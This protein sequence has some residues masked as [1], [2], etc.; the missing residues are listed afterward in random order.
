MNWHTLSARDAL[1][2]LETD[3]NHGLNQSL[4]NERYERY[5]PNVFDKPRPVSLG[6]RILHHLRDIS[7]IILLIAALIAFYM[8]ATTGEG[9]AKVGVILLIVV[10]NVVLAITQESK[11]EKAL[12]T[13]A[14]VNAHHCTA[15]RCGALMTIPASELVPGDIIGLAAGDR[16]PADA[17]LTSANNLQV[18]EAMLTGESMP[19][20][21]DPTAA[22]SEEAPLAERL[23]VVYSGSYVSAGRAE[24]VVYATG[25]HTEMGKIAL[26]LNTTTKQVT[27]LQKRLEALAK[28]IA[29]IALGSGILIFLIGVVVYGDPL[30]QMLLTGISLAVAAVPETLPVIVTLIMANGIRAMVEAKTIIRRMPAVETVGSTSIICSDKTGTLTQNKMVIRKLWR[31]DGPV[32][33]ASATFSP[34]EQHMLEMLAACTNAVPA[35]PEEIEDHGNDIIGDP[36][37]AAIVR[38]LLDKGYTRDDLDER[39]PRVFELPF[40]STRKLMTTVHTTPTGYLSITKGA[41]DRIPLTQSHGDA[42]THLLAQQ[43]HDTFA[44]QALRVLAVATREWTVLPEIMDAAHL[45]KDLDL[46]GVVGLIDPPRPESY[47]AVAAAKKAG[48]RTVMITG[49][50]SATAAAIARDIGILEGDAHVVSGVELARMS[51]AE[52]IERVPE[53]AVYARVSPEDKI[54]IV[55]AWQE[56]GEVIT[57]TGDGVNDAPALKAADV[58]AA[59]GIAGTDVSKNAADVIITDDNFATIVAAVREG[60]TAYDNIRKVVHFLLSVNFAEILVM[61]IGVVVGWGAPINSVQLLFINVIADG[62]PGFSLSR[63]PAEANLMNRVPLK[64]NASLFAEGLGR[65][66]GLTSAI[67]IGLTLAAFAIGRFVP[68]QGLA[69]DYVRGTTM[70]FLVLAWSSALNIFNVRAHDSLLAKATGRNAWLNGCVALS[71]LVSALAVLLPFTQAS[72]GL[73]PLSPAHWLIAAV[74]SSLILIFGEITKLFLRPKQASSAIE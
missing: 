13:L 17:R 65:K 12:E 58:G 16:V 38:L 73:V 28:R 49:D 67:F 63:E 48:I 52:L 44:E 37:E 64:K 66:I 24:A 74:L 20:S 41:F 56:R 46:V 25:M 54:R 71:L 6:A 57:M 32:Q 68:L 47:R 19:V 15:L 1:G 61:L 70:A 31:A 5:G 33:D 18:E 72:F 60:R 55:Q 35:S 14:K 7:T 69:A 45:E 51:H 27:P 26:L 3:P 59:M 30:P 40:D 29:L 9:W 34:A 8:A 39:Y 53:I 42:E 4:I 50:H 22:I 11:A 2:E 10:I 43:I 23:T 36:T 62:I 21:K